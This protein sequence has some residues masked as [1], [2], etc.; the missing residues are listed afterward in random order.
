MPSVWER[1]P[2]ATL[3][4]AGEGAL[5][6]HP[7]LADP[8]VEVRN[9]YIPDSAVPALFA[10]VTCCVLPYREA[11]QSGVGSRAKSHG[12]AI[13]ATAVGGL[14]ELVGPESG[15]IVPAGDPSAL[16]DAVVEVL[17]T[18]GLAAAM[19]AA[20]AEAVQHAGWDRVGAVTLDAYE[21]HLAPRHSGAGV[22]RRD[23]RR[24]RP[25]R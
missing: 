5:E 21:R 25:V 10:A 19:G 12:R 1:I 18:P 17:A 11:S 9:H 7:A 20:A 24:R 2:D 23:D 16:A 4:I 6:E 22:R 3:T 13:V 8:R 14:P 15:R